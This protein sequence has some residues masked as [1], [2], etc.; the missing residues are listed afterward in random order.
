M[1]ILGVPPKDFPDM[2]P[3]LEWH[4]Q[5]FADRAR[6]EAT[7]RRLVDEVMSGERQCWIAWDGKVRACALTKVLDSAIRTVE[8]THCAGEGREDWQRQMIET[9]TSWAREIGS[10]RF[11]T[12]NRPGWARFLK[13]MGLQETH[14]VMEVDFGG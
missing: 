7:A 8:M 5:S 3:A 11:R 2:Y 1:N 9:L 4:F 6:G 10:A 14:R 13:T 12:I